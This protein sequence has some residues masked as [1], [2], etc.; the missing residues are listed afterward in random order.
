MIPTDLYLLEPEEA[1]TSGLPM[2]EQVKLLDENM[3]A[4]EK[5]LLAARKESLAK[6]K[7]KFDH[8]Q[9]EEVFYPEE[10]VLYYNRIGARRDEKEDVGR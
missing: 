8:H 9:V 10:H 5:L 6:N 4:A 3:K 2:A 7:E 1:G